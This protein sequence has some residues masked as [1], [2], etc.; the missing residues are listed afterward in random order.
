MMALR[1]EEASSAQTQGRDGSSDTDGDGP[2]RASGKD[3]S[4]E[5]VFPSRTVA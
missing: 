5:P 1:Q 3:L 4:K 2:L